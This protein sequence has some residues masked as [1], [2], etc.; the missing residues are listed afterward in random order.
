MIRCDAVGSN[1]TLKKNYEF[2]QGSIHLV[3]A[4]RGG[5][6]QAYCIGLFSGVNKLPFPPVFAGEKLLN[7]SSQGRITMDLVLLT[8]TI[9]AIRSNCFLPDKSVTEKNSASGRVISRYLF[10][11]NIYYHEQIFFT[12]AKMVQNLFLE[13]HIIPP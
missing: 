5:L 3:I 12:Y 6:I 2:F 11:L 13:Q 9:K 7:N 1:R 4:P 8:C 10:T